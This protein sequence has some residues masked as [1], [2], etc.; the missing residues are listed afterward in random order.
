MSDKDK[1]NSRLEASFARWIEGTP[2][3]S[4]GMAILGMRPV[5]REKLYRVYAEE[6]LRLKN[7]KFASFEDVYGD[8]MKES[9]VDP[10]WAANISP[11]AARFMEE[12]EK[13]FLAANY[14]YLE[15]GVEHAWKDILEGDYDCGVP[16]ILRAARSGHGRALLYASRLFRNGVGVE[17]DPQKA[18]DALEAAAETD[19]GAA[20]VEYGM[21]LVDGRYGETDDVTGKKF[22]EKA[23]RL[24]DPDTYADL[25]RI[26]TSGVLGEGRLEEGADFLRR[27]VRNGSGQAAY[28]LGLLLSAGRTDSRAMTP[29]GLLQ[30]SARRGYVPAMH[31]LAKLFL[32]EARTSEE[33]NDLSPQECFSI[34]AHWLAR[35]ARLGD[36]EA[37]KLMKAN[38]TMTL[39][40]GT[41]ARVGDYAG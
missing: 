35:A 39:S 25:G 16:E 17:K 40:D 26:L 10:A 36:A 32:R 13:R 30:L 23:V 37:E 12:C 1:L 8:L 2:F 3:S 29:L 6:L 19:C 9:G 33:G 14:R 24:A 5:N 4:R 11:E 34:G 28:D 7:G 15:R 20:C 21:A 27:G 18:M 38:L 41:V 31:D 22:L